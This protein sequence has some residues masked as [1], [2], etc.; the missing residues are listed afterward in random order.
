MIKSSITYKG[1]P[2]NIKSG[3]HE[4]SWRE[5]VDYRKAPG[6]VQAVK[7][8]TGR[9]LDEESAKV[10]LSFCDWLITP[11]DLEEFVPDELEI[12]G[13]TYNFNLDVG[14]WPFGVKMEVSAIV[15]HRDIIE[16]SPSIVATVVSTNWRNY[17]EIARNL[18]L[19]PFTL[20]CSASK[21][22]IKAVNKY[23]KVW[24]PRIRDRFK[25][26][27]LKGRAEALSKFGD[28]TTLYDMAQGLP[29]N[30]AG[31]KDITTNEIMTTRFYKNQL[32]KLND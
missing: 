11:P 7:L 26:A 21:L 30:Y 15:E 20:V 27:K 32:Q 9:E 16:S 4:L 18:E 12:D 14:S 10:V 17:A 5:V 31:V 24:R 2:L 28:F 6:L 13:K 3:W 29:T 19:A 23:E 8:A 25:E 1:E 22:I